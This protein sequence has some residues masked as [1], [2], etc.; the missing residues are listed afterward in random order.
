M[1]GWKET[2]DR[3]WGNVNH[4][5]RIGGNV[6]VGSIDAVFSYFED[7]NRLEGIPAAANTNKINYYLKR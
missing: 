3:F 1:F 2:V 7:S 4:R 5:I 6:F